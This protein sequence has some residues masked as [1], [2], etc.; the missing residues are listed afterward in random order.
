VAIDDAVE[1][2]RILIALLMVATARR[3]GTLST[4]ST[5]NAT[6]HKGCQIK[7]IAALAIVRPAG[8]GTVEPTQARS[9]ASILRPEASRSSPASSRIGARAEAL[10]EGRE[11]D[12]ALRNY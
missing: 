12:T 10:V 9:S 3:D 6:T 4:A 5:G 1:E 8:S 11:L 7:A 2:A